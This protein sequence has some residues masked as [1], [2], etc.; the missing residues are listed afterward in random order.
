MANDLYDL[1]ILSEM[2]YGDKEFMK[3]LIDTFIEFAPIDTVELTTY[4]NDKN[5][6]ETSKKAHKLKSSIRTIGVTS[7]NELIIDIELNAKNETQLLEMKSKI[8]LFSETLDKVLE[9]LKQEK[10]ESK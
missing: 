2:V 8:D 7:L 10:F 3:E 6:E 5:W 4:S 9:S 1:S